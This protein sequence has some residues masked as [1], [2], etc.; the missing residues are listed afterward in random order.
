MSVIVSYRAVIKELMTQVTDLKK[1][2]ESL[3]KRVCVII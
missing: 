3:K 1:E 2:N